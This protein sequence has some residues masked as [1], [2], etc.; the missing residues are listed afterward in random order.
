MRSQSQRSH[1]VISFY[2]I[3]KYLYMAI[4]H[5]IPDYVSGLR[6]CVRYVLGDD[7]SE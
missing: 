7:V 4:I 6:E 1:V 2:I 3:I 5:I